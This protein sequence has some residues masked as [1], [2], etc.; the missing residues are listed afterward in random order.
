[1]LLRIGKYI[2]GLVIDTAAALAV[3]AGL[4]LS[5]CTRGNGFRR[6]LGNRTSAAGL[7]LFDHQRFAPRILKTEGDFQFLTFFDLSEILGGIQ[8]LDRGELGGIRNDIAGDRPRL[9]LIL[10]A[11]NKAQ[12]YKT[13]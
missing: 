5:F 4:Y 11:G 10:T 2:E 1:M 13:G 12:N 8:P 3:K 6:L 9:I 7:Y